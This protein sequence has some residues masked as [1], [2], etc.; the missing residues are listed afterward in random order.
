MVD[1]NRPELNTIPL[2]SARVSGFHISDYSIQFRGV[3]KDCRSKEK[4]Q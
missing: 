2:P 4:S 3:C 1:F